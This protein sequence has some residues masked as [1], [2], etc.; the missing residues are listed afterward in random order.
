MSPFVHLASRGQSRNDVDQWRDPVN[1]PDATG[2]G[3][4]ADKSYHPYLS[5]TPA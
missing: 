3:T 5:S 4:I 2:I 1:A